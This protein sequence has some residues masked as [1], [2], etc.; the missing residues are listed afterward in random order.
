[1]P[2]LEHIRELRSR[3]LK[4]LFFLLIGAIIGF[5][6]F[7]QVWDFLQKP[8]CKLEVNKG[9]DAGTCGLYVTGLTAGFFVYLKIAL[10]IGA[11][12]SSPF[13]LYQLWA[14]VA[15]GLHHRE[16]RW[17][18]IFLA[19]AIPLFLSGAA[20]AYFTLDKGL[21]ILLGFTPGGVTNIVTIDSYLGYMIAMLLI[22][23]ISFELPLFVVILNLAG[24]LSHEKLAKHRRMIIFGLFVFAAV[25]TPS[26]DPFTMLALALPTVVLFLFAEL[27]AFFH[28]KRKAKR[29]ELYDGLSDDEASVIEDEPYDIGT[30]EPL[31][32]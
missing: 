17:T 32:R 26:A 10:I 22:F 20:L 21:T 28:D 25:A 31:D 1:M 30:P 5:L 27:I 24:V 8:Y 3:L 19:C 16:K 29:T 4:A 12:L 23:G 6:V 11:I 18:Y 7:D 14:F 15:P 2:L 13:W 9:E